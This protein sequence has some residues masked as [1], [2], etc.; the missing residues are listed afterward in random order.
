MGQ[1]E[2]RT[3]AASN[4]P[5][6]TTW[7]TCNVQVVVLYVKDI[8]ERSTGDISHTRTCRYCLLYIEGSRGHHNTP[9]LHPQEPSRGRCT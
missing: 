8:M 7:K 1:E 6:H 9:L 5:T 3:C 2:C 4:D